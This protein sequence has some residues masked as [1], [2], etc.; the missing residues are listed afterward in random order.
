[1]NNILS[2]CQEQ[3]VTYVFAL[4]RKA[5]GCAVGKLVPV[6]IVGVF[7]FSGTEVI[8]NLL[9]ISSFNLFIFQSKYKELISLVRDAQERYQEMISIYQHEIT[10]S[11]DVSDFIYKFT[12]Q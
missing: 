2:I 4:G 9:I 6:S 1:M 7:D 8:E 12:F 5:L 11:S 3:K 10:T